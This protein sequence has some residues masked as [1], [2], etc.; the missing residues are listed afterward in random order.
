[1]VES[2]K[3]I[4]EKVEIEIVKLN[5][6]YCMDNVEG[7]RMIADSSID[8]TVTSPP[9]DNLRDYN[10]YSFNFEDVAKELYRITKE[11]GGCLGGG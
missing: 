4:H 6:I 8:L 3:E 11:G 5:N 9:Y 2:E 10:G 7:M 1:M